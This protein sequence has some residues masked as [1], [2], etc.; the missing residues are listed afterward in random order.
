[1]NKTP[2]TEQEVRT[3]VLALAKTVTE[4]S[5]KI[6]AEL[7]ARRQEF[8]KEWDRWGKPRSPKKLV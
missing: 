5:R 3:A 2:K 7:T 6:T 8:N 4:E 1:M